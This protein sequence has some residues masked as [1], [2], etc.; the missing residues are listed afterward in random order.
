MV[1]LKALYWYNRQREEELETSHFFFSRFVSI[2]QNLTIGVEE[3]ILHFK[4]TRHNQPPAGLSFSS[5]C[6]TFV[7]FA[8]FKV[9]VMER[10]EKMNMNST[11]NS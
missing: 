10:K 1:H 6:V 4:G 5:S 11:W 7:N 8:L 2:A 9:K 3:N